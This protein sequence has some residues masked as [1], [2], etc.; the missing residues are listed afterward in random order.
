M[1]KAIVCIRNVQ[2]VVMVAGELAWKFMEAF[3][4]EFA[5]SDTPS[6]ATRIRPVDGY[7]EHPGGWHVTVTVNEA[8]EG[9]L[10]AFC[11]NFS[12]AHGV[13]F[14]GPGVQELS[15]DDIHPAIALAG[16][17]GRQVRL[18]MDLGSVVAGRFCG[19]EG[20]FAVINDGVTVL[21][22]PLDRVKKV[23]FLPAT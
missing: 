19:F 7:C 21:P 1:S 4:E 11:K 2:W 6:G 23:V 20:P 3:G 17:E 10:A 5:V 16:M 15:S 8:E 12:D 14:R 22:H 18:E 13:I 9:R